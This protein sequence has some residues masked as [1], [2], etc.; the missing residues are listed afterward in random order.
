[1]SHVS[2]HHRKECGIIPI[3]TRGMIFNMWRTTFSLLVLLAALLFSL[4]T[5]A[6]PPIDE[7]RHLADFS[8]AN[9]MGH[10]RAISTEPHPS[11]SAAN[12]RVRAYI[13]HQ[14]EKL[15]LKVE[16]QVADVPARYGAPR[17]IHNLIT[18]LTANPAGKQEGAILLCAHYDSVSRGPGAAD[19]GAAVGALLEVMRAL[20]SRKVARRDILFLFTDGEERGLLGARAF[21]ADDTFTSKFDDAASDILKPRPKSHPWLNE[22]AIVLNFDARGTSGPSIMYETAP[23]NLALLRLYASSDQTAIASSL[24][25]DV[26]RLMRNDSDFTIFR[27]A[28][29]VGLNFA[30]SGGYTNYHTENDTVQNL[31]Q[32][33]MYHHGRHALALAA[34]LSS[35]SDGEL[36]ALTSRNQ[37]DAIAFNLWPGKLIVYPQTWNWPLTILQ[38]IITIA[39]FVRLHRN[40]RIAIGDWLASFFWM[41]LAI[42]LAALASWSIWKATGAPQA[43]A[44]IDRQ[45]IVHAGA[46]LAIVVL[47]ATVVRFRSLKRALQ[48]SAR[49]ARF[50]ERNLSI[51][52]IFLFS[53][54]AIPINLYAPGGSYLTTWPPLCA[55]LALLVADRN[56]LGQF[57]AVVLVAPI[58]L[59]CAP[60]FLLAWTALTLS[61][62]P[63]FAPLLVLTAMI[64]LSICP[65][66]VRSDNVAHLTPPAQ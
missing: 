45:M 54:L 6:P 57:A 60:L 33:S 34:R 36:A 19:N 44:E 58:L 48:G 61:L 21:C 39:V 2:F 20:Q 17:I 11:E 30:F 55:S 28:G 26:Y 15:G 62:S 38:W 35:L 3:R 4:R 51:A 1:M 14:V 37:P 27:R 7:P 18:R 24:S 59:I 8:N 66:I 41:L 64:L 43:T 47:C 9:A 56:L 25:N 49:R 46:A 22:L 32:R 63:L 31:D 13:T 29:K 53:L 40:R 23:Q 5:A 50:S 10:V 16:Q 65:P 12:N 42:L 52:P